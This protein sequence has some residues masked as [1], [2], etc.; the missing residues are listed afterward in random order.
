MYRLIP[1]SA[2]ALYRQQ[3]AERLAAWD[4]LVA[5]WDREDAQRTGIRD[6]IR[7]QHENG[8]RDHDAA[9]RERWGRLPDEAE[10]EEE[11][12]AASVAEPAAPEPEPEPPAA[13]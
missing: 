11:P 8:T 10:P 6:A 7:Q 3:R 1:D 9:F 13:A 4:D 2:V 5:L 12:A